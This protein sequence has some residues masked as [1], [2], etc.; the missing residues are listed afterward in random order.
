MLMANFENTLQA[1]S[2]AILRRELTESERIE[3]LELAGAIGMGSVE[4]YLYMLMIF[5]R[6]EDRISAQMAS[7]RKEMKARFDEL[8]VLEKKIDATLGKTL[9]DMLGKGA[10][11]I[12]YAM[13]RDIVDS[14]K[15]VLN[16]NGDFHFLR[17]QVLT[18]CITS[19]MAALAYWLGSMGTFDFSE[20]RSFFWRFFWFPAGGLMII[21]SFAYVYFWYF[22]HEG[23]IGQYPTYMIKFTLQ[24]LILLAL[25]LHVLAS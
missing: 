3:F 17:G 21:C 1:A 6:N 19:L 12:G 2:Q 16:K 8:G 23:W 4:D 15:E 10:E 9:E 5:K 24:I 13:G 20:G 18:V 22:D 11:K 14:A 25:L 7:F